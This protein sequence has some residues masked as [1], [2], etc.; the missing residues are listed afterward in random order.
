LP[1]LA[2]ELVDLHPDVIVSITT[3]ATAAMKAATDS[4]PIVF[5]YVGDPWEPASSPACHTPAET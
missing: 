5:A 2:R 4:I 3:P 1:I